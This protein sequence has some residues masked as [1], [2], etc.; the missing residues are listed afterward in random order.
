MKQCD[1]CPLRTKGG[2]VPP[3]GP[4]GA[5]IA[6][7]G[8]AP[9]RTEVRQGR[10]FVGESGQLLHAAIRA[11]GQDPTKFYYTNVCKC[12][13]SKNKAVD[14]EA[15]SLCSVSLEEEFKAR[16]IELII[17][18]GNS[19]LQGL[20]LG[21]QGISKVHGSSLKWNGITVFPTYHPASILYHPG[22]WPDFSDDLEEAL[23]EGGPRLELAPEFNNYSVLSTEGSLRFLKWL[24]QQPFVYFDI[25]TSNLKILDTTILSIAFACGHDYV[26]VIPKVVFDHAEVRAA[27]RLACA[28]P[29]LKW[30][31]HN[32]QFDAAR[33]ITQYRAHPYISE[34][35]LL[36]HYALDERPGTHDLKTLAKKFL[37]VPDWEVGIKKWINKDNSSYAM[38]PEEVLWKYNARDVAYGYDLHQLFRPQVAAEPDLERLYTELL[39]PGTNALVDMSVRGVKIDL[40]NLRELQAEAEKTIAALRAAMQEDLK[41]PEFNPNSHPQVGH[42]IYDVYKSPPFSRSKPLPVESSEPASAPYG[43]KDKTTAKDQLKRLAQPCY[44]CSKFA[45][46][47]VQYREA[48]Q[49]IKTYLSNLYPESDGRVHPGLRLFGTVTGRLSGSKPNMMNLTR[50]GPIRSLIVPEPGNILLTIDYKASELRVLCALAGSKNLLELFKAGKDPHNYVGQHIYSDK[51]NPELHRTGV[52]EVNFG[53]AYYRGAKSISEAL[54]VSLGVAKQIRTMVINLLGVDEWQQEQLRLVKTQQYVTTPTGRRRRFPLI[55]AK[56]WA[57]IGRQAINMPVQGT[58]SDMCTLS[59]IET[60]KWIGQYGGTILFP[61]HDSLLLEFPTEHIS[62]VAARVSQEMLDA[63]THILGADFTAGVDI[64]VGYS[65]DKKDMKEYIVEKEKDGG[66]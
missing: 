51:Y 16:G 43:R 2:R 54:G 47:M 62:S 20:G 40:D 17:A 49:L 1:T 38:I 53:V 50:T 65:Y 64:A 52:K 46:Q 63:G 30:A 15:L 12:A 42:I 31:G 3:F 18:L 28:A 23:R 58:S 13:L 44:P 56:L 11:C 48:H 21:A 25:E 4:K 35:T 26:V 29:S 34:D 57:D 5:K 33:L 24:K 32:A 6:F 8:E 60:N 45:T 66:R 37:R 7:L 27:L 39:I 41:D 22:N 9:G 59:L 19:A 61:T 36:E 10:P 55:L 14:A